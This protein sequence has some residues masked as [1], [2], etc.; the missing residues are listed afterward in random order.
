MNLHAA[1]AFAALLAA[2][3]LLGSMGATAQDEAPEWQQEEV[4][5]LAGRLIHAM[6][7][8]LAD[9]SFDAKQATAMQ[10]R[11]HDAAVSSVR[12]LRRLVGDYKKR[13]DAGYDRDETEPFFAQ[14][15]LLRGDIRDYARRSWLPEDT[16]AK[17]ERAAGLLDQ[18]ARYYPDL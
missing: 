11:E 8:V 13:L 18:L 14:M 7:E 3:L 9:P 2:A 10:Q 17:V 4:Q 16:A 6:D 15:S 5:A 1:S 12:E